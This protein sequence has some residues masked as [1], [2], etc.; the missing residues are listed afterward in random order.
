MENAVD[1]LKMAAAV[2]VFII[3][4]ASSFS[5]FGTAKQ[6]ADSIITK[7]DKQAYLESA[8]LDG[9]ILYT[10]S[11]VIQGDTTGLTESQIEAQKKQKSSIATVTK[12]GDRI[13]GRED[14]IS[15]IL[16][17]NKEKYGVTI[18]TA[19]GTVLARYD[20]STEGLMTQWHTIVDGENIYGELRTAQEQKEDFVE[21]I[22]NNIQNAYVKKEN[23][24][25]D[26]DDLEEIYKIKLVGE[27]A[28]IDRRIKCGAPWYG[29]EEQ[30]Q[31]RIACDIS[32]PT[33]KYQYNNQEYDGKDLLSKLP[34]S[35]DSRYIVEVTNEIDKS[36]YLKDTEGGVDVETNLLQ[37]FEM[38]TLEIVYIIF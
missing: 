11:D 29:N 24:H 37:Q 15:T 36:T 1:A 9:G 13:V 6:T 16:R 8:E 5:L 32:G 19:T 21:D 23:I 12:N 28:A 27:A 31:K 35:A 38:P 30:I 22:K 2:L 20:S 4:L 25:F 7:R 10:S 3:A 33:A 17:Y 14:V 18:I 34:S 26:V